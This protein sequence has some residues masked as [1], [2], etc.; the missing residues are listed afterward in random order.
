MKV[1]IVL[2][3]YRV[4]R[5]LEKYFEDALNQRGLS[6]IEFSIVHNDP[7]EKEKEIIEKY[8]DRL[9]IVYQ[10][11]K[12]E[13]LYAS[14]NRAILQSNGEY[15]ACWN[16][17]DLRKHDSISRMVELLDNNPDVGFTYGDIV[18]SNGFGQRNGRRI[19]VPEY[20]KYLGTTSAIGGPFFMW[21]KKLVG[22]VGFFDEQFKSGGDFDYTIRLSIFSKGKKT[23]GIIGYFLHDGTGLSTRDHDL[24][25]LERTVVELRYGVWFKIDIDYITDAFN[26]KINSLTENGENRS[27]DNEIL[28]LSKSR[29]LWILIVFYGFFKN[30][31]IN[32]LRYIKRKMISV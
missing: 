5:Y 24:Q 30:S 29:A 20:T 17:D 2:S 18:V 15:L 9:N 26:Y 23:R 27:V 28:R 14:W 12:L 32:M 11:V 22:K 1:S 7:T 13:S 3:L 10:E 25:I 19:I 21:R 6:D 4:E 16:V 8:N 31:L